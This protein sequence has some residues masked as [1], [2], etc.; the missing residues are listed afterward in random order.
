MFDRMGAL[1]AGGGEAGFWRGLS[2]PFRGMR[3]VYLDHPELIR[4]WILP[5]LLTFF[6]FGGAIIGAWALHDD[7]V[8]WLWDDPSGEG[9]W[10]GVGRF[11]HGL[12]ELLVFLLLLVTALFV[13]L[14]LS[15]VIASP[16]ND[17]LSARASAERG[18]V[19]V[20]SGGA[21]RGVGRSIGIETA[22]FLCWA[23][24]MV[25]LFIASFA[26]PGVGH[27]IY[28]AVGFV[29]TALYFTLDYLDWPAARRGK[30]MAYRRQLITRRFRT[31]LGFGTGVFLFLWVPVLNL[32]FMPAAVAGGTL[33]FLDMEPPSGAGGSDRNAQAAKATGA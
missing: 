29:F 15:S 25:P 17:A 7:L 11:F 3:F 19:A 18:D 31:S 1:Q 2:Y 22:K 5:I 24:V 33:L 6:A 10:D 13:V 30:P 27:L 32:F 14:G 12:V 20:G 4:I 8:G 28:S 16:F 9:L 21:L 23:M 26:L